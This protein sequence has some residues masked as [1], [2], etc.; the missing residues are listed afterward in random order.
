MSKRGRS[1]Q[2]F[3]SNG[4][5]RLT[6]ADPLALVR[7]ARGGLGGGRLIVAGSIASG[8]QIADLAHAGADAFTIGTA[9]F[10]DAFAAD[11]KGVGSQIRAVQA[12]CK[13]AKAATP[14][15]T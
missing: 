15:A 2:K 9:V 11:A 4:W 3:L 1:I 5:R 12:A 13:A 10:E 8:R 6:E 14:H 7:A